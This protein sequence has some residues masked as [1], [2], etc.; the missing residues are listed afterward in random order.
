[1]KIKTIVL[2]LL[3]SVTSAAQ[4][5]G[6]KPDRYFEGILSYTYHLLDADGNNLPFPIEE[7]LE[8]RDENHILNRVIKGESI[9][10]IGNQEIYLDSEMNEA[11]QIDH[12]GKSITK[13]LKSKP[14]PIN[15]IEFRKMG[16]STVLNYLCDIYRI[17]Y[18]HEMRYMKSFFEIKPDT[19]TCTF[20]IARNLK[21]PNQ[22]KFAE[23]QGNNNG[24]IIDG[25]FPGITLKVIREH[26]DGQ[27]MIIEIQSIEKR[28]MNDFIKLP[29]YAFKD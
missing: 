2:I 13:I 14:E 20:Y 7:D 10:M 27:K 6:S 3:L 29:P 17:Q 8:Y 12:D 28:E 22:K 18:I 21:A 16:E 19:V 1:V 26:T 15:P 24:K 9:R 23:L 5:Q 25:R 4:S 11:Y